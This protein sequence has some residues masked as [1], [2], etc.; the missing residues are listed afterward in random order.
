MKQTIAPIGMG[1]IMGL[2]MLW[3]LH[4]QLTGQDVS[5]VALTAFVAAH[6]VILLIIIG[7][8]VFAARLSPGIRQK[9][10][11]LHRPSSRHMGKMLGSA[12]TTALTIH[13]ILHGVG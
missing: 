7:A 11:R 4:G 2:M 6:G 9:L 3:M 1:I 13:L 8:G 5:L 10:D 12:T